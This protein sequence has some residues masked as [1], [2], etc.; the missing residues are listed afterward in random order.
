MADRP[1]SIPPPWRELSPFR[2][3][4]TRHLAD[5]ETRHAFQALGSFLFAAALE[6]ATTTPPEP[7]EVAADLQAVAQDLGWIAEF[8]RRVVSASVQAFELQPQDEALAALA[9]RWAVEVDAVV[10]RIHEALSA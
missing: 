8:M 10:S 5:E 6:T 7:S 9:G 4:F 2:T 3:V 1:K